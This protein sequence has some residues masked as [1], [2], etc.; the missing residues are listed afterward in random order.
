[1]CATMCNF[2]NQKHVAERM[3]QTKK[4]KRLTL[5]NQSYF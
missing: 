2:T 4:I 5:F 1:M 3:A